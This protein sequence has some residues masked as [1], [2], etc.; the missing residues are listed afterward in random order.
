MEETGEQ[1]RS[2]DIIRAAKPAIMLSLVKRNGDI[3]SYSY[4][5]LYRSCLRKNRLLL[6]FTSD[7]IELI[8]SNLRKL[9]RPL[10]DGR[11]TVIRE[12][13]HRHHASDDD[14]VIEQILI[15]ARHE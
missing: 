8:G 5:H 1:D 13:A 3:F 10:G 15:G 11:V 7:R 4:S 2:F 9:Y 14:T 12:S 6:E